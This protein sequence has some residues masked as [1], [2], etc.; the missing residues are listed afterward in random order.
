MT[1]PRQLRPNRNTRGHMCN[2]QTSCII[3]LLIMSLALTYLCIW[4]SE[5]NRD[6]M[7]KWL[8]LITTKL[9]V[10]STHAWHGLYMYCIITKNVIIPWIFK[11]NAFLI[12]F[13]DVTCYTELTTLSRRFAK[14]NAVLLKGKSLV[15][16]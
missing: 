12:L 15:L 5:Y 9:F 16:D 10:L 2:P 3:I 4:N 13:A 6:N 14:P 8:E 7:R 11:L 1:S